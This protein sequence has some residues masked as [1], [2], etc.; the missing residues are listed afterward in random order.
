[1]Q[2]RVIQ[3]YLACTTCRE[4]AKATHVAA[5]AGRLWKRHGGDQICKLNGLIWSRCINNED[6]TTQAAFAII[7]GRRSAGFV[8]H[9]CRADNGCPRGG[10]GE[11]QHGD[12]YIPDYKDD[13]RRRFWVSA[14][15]GWTARVGPSTGW[16]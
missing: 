9:L 10:D 3:G 6:G 11:Q 4:K 12:R 1:M 16:Y 15:R 13:W 14:T 5:V 7:E 8:H 2:R